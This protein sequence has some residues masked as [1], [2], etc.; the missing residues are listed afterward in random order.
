MSQVTAVT[1]ISVI[2]AVRRAAAIRR[3]FPTK[4]RTR[5]IDTQRINEILAGE[6]ANS[7]PS[8]SRRMKSGY[9]QS[10]GG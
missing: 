6:A 8:A 4:L 7:D 9:G 5:L 3:D 1:I 2:L 10:Q